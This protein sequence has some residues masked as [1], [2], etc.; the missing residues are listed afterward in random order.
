MYK[1]E[2][3]KCDELKQFPASLTQAHIGP[4]DAVCAGHPDEDF[5]IMI[6]SK[7][8]KII[9]RTGDVT[10]Y[11]DENPVEFCGKKYPKAIRSADCSAIAAGRCGACVKYRANLRSIYKQWK[12]S[13]TTSP[14]SHC[15]ERYPEKKDKMSK[16]RSQVNALVL[17][18]QEKVATLIES[19][20]E[21]VDDDLHTDL[22]SI[23]QENNDK[24]CAD[25]PEGSF[26]WLLWNEQKKVASVKNG[27]E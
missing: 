22:C 17:R 8:G 16:L 23:M 6:Q 25:F 20:G 14:S 3:T 2:V 21:P 1:R 26:Q 7:K 11:L 9:S 19:R 4:Y 27:T 10:S 15:N 18:L 13:C 24:I 5:V 12:K